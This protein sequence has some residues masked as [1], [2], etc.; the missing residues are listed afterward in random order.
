MVIYVENNMAM[1]MMIFSFVDS[2]P[3]HCKTYVLYDENF[4]NGNTSSGGE[5]LTLCMD[6]DFDDS[7]YQKS[8]SKMI[9]PLC[10][11]YYYTYYST[12]SGYRNPTQV[13]VR[14]EYGVSSLC[15]SLM[16]LATRRKGVGA[17][18]DILLL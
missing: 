3:Q 8:N 7:N 9:F 12:L 13:G 18:V 17:L 2:T 11:T 1:M 14:V 15:Q 4:R 16:T 10:D 5:S 6:F